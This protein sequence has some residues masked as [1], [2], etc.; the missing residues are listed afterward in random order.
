M[1]GS[2]YG[3]GNHQ[4]GLTGGVD[5]VKQRQQFVG[6]LGVQ[7]TGGFVGQNKLGTGNQGAGNGNTLLL[8]A[9]YF[10]GIFFLEGRNS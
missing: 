2:L 9:G 6:C 1:A 3:V 10:I 7:R 8:S 4:N 5:L